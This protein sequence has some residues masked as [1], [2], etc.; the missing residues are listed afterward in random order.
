MSSVR[1]FL[2]TV[3]TGSVVIFMGCSTAP[4]AK[5]Y[6]PGEDFISLWRG[7]Q[8]HLDQAWSYLGAV[9]TPVRGMILDGNLTP[10][11][12]IKTLIFVQNTDTGSALLLFSRVDK[13][14]PL[15]I[16]RYLGGHKVEIEGKPYREAYYG[17]DLNAA[18]FEYHRYFAAVQ[19][20]GF[21]LAPHYR[22]R[23]LDRLPVD[24]TLVRVMELYPGTAPEFLPSYGRLYPQERREP[25]PHHIF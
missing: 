25:L 6:Q 1:L 18:D 14:S 17:L 7:E 3:M 21:S 12:Q 10:V 19:E 23:V 9:Q 24:S 22:V 4:F 13:I 2:I 20:H 15:E 5:R 11:D 16:F 8:I